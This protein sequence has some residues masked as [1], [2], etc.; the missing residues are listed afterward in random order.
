MTKYKTLLYD[1]TDNIA[2]ITMN[3]QETLNAIS[4]EMLDELL[5]VLFLSTQDPR[6]RVLVLTGNGRA[7]SS[8][9]D[10]HIMEG[11]LDKNPGAFMTEWITRVHLLEMQIR[12][13][14]KPVI[15]A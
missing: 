7:F 6:V 10:I 15:A 8:G 5:H 9:G 14:A 2:T 1:V 12:T 4:L 3:R 13:I 11:L